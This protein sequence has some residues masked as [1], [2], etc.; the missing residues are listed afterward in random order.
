MNFSA[1]LYAR[2]FLCLKQIIQKRTYRIQNRIGLLDFRCRTDETKVCLQTLARR[3]I[4]TAQEGADRPKVW[5]LQ[6]K[7]AEKIR[8]AVRFVRSFKAFSDLK[9]SALKATA[10]FFMMP[11]APMY[12]T[13]SSAPHNPRYTAHRRAPDKIPRTS[14]PRRPRIR[15]KE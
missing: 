4:R 3:R 11:A 10:P 15:S 8:R 9:R 14:P 12:Q 13:I 6:S 1:A 7:S 2:R 5:L